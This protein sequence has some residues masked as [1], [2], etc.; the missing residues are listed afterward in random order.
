MFLRIVFK[1]T[2]NTVMVFTVMVSS[3]ICSCSLNLVYVFQNQKKLGTIYVVFLF[4][5]LVS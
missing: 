2:E 1:N 4:V 3:E 5:L